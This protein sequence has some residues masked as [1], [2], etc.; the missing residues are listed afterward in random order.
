MSEA[1]TI[2]S[3]ED[4]SVT[5]LDQATGELYHN[6]AGA[7]TEALKNYV[8]PCCL[9]SKIGS[10]TNIRLLDICFGLGYNSY[11]FLDQLINLFDNLPSLPSPLQI[12]ILG[13]DQDAKIL[14]VIPTVLADPRF[15]RLLK[16]LAQLSNQET[17]QVKDSFCRFGAHH[18]L[19]NKEIDLQFELRL[20]DIRQ[21][22]PK[23]VKENGGTFD[24]VFHDGFSPHKMPELWTRDLFNLYTE[25]IKPSGC[26]LTYSSAT[27]VRGAFKECGLEVKKTTPVGGKSGGTIA[28]FPG[29]IKTD[30]YILELSEN[31]QLRLASRSSV[32]YR[33]PDLTDNR[34]VILHR[35]Q[36]ELA[37]C[38]HL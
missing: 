34:Q 4:G 15:A 31:E 28:A 11:V 26:I 6:K 2:I 19:L 24:F 32:P 3:T 20:A 27:A 37:G 13:I 14:T 35:R 38:Q 5:C 18:F 17:D 25:L 21:A 16:R 30:E 1:L 36:E 10:Q 9:S 23:L 12:K 33:D 7:F 8:E 22:L 29:Q